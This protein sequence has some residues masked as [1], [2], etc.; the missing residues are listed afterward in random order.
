[1]PYFGHRIG[2][3]DIAR[4][5]AVNRR[6]RCLISAIGYGWVGEGLRAIYL[7]PGELDDESAINSA[8]R[9]ILV[10]DRWK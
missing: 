9:N 4:H 5:L 10:M 3:E 8:D 7:P 6:T 1:M 2:C